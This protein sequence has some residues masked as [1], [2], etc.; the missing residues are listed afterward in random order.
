MLKALELIGFKSFPDKTRFEFP[1]GITVVVGP[2]G[3]GK[4][5]VVDAMKWVLGEQSARSLRGK[6][7]ADVIFKGSA[8]G[9]RKPA[10]TAQVTIIF[11]NSN[12]LLPVDEVEVHVTR[13]VYRSGEGEYLING[14]ACRLRDVRDLFRG[15]GVG[16]D[17]YSLIEQGKV[18]SLLQASAK[19]RRAI[20]E[21]AA[22]ISRFKAKKVEAERRLERVEQNLLRLSDIVE[23][24]ETRLKRLRSQATKATRYKEYTDRLQSLRTHVGRVDWQRLSEQLQGI[25]TRLT[26]LQ[27]E[28]ET[29][30]AELE[31]VEAR[32]AAE[33]T[34]ISSNEQALREVETSAGRYREQ[35]A[36]SRSTVAQQ[37]QTLHDLHEELSRGRDRLC[38]ARSKAREL[39]SQLEQVRGT[40][41][42]AESA[43]E[44]HRL[45][46]ERRRL[47]WHQR[48]AELTELR[49]QTEIRRAD[50]VERMRVAADVGN[51]IAGLELQRETVR[52]A[53]QKS[54]SLVE[55]ANR[56]LAVA[57][58][59][60]EAS[61]REAENSRSEVS[62]LERRITEL[63]SQAETRSA[64]IE[65]SIRQLGDLRERQT[66]QLARADVLREFEARMEGVGGGVK[67]VLAAAREGDARYAGVRGMI[68][69]IVRVT[70]AEMAGMVDVALGE[71]AQHL[72]VAGQQLFDLLER[73]QID[74]P[75]RV[76]FLRLQSTPPPPSAGWV[77]LE[78]Q[79]GVI[80]RADRFVETSS[81]YQHLVGWLLR[82]TWFVESL[83]DAI[84][85]H[86]TVSAPIRMVTRRGELLDR[87]GRLVVGPLEHGVG[88]I[89]RRAEL[90]EIERQARELEVEIARQHAEL[91]GQKEQLTRRQSERNDLI[92]EK[93]VLAQALSR[94]ELHVATATERAEQSRRERKRSAEELEQATRQ[95]AETERLWSENRD[96]LAQ[97]E[98]TIRGLE[99]QL[100]SDRESTSQ[101]EEQLQ[102]Q[103][104]EVTQWE[105]EVAKSE[106]RVEALKLQRT[107]LE[108]DQKDRE[109]QQRATTDELVRSQQRLQ[110]AELH[111][112]GAQTQIAEQSIAEQACRQ[113]I[114]LLA[115]QQIR[116]KQQRGSLHQ[117]ASQLRDRLHDAE[118]QRHAVQLD[119]QRIKHQRDTLFSRLEE[120]YGVSV[121]ELEEQPTEEETPQRD[122]IDREIDE[123]R[124]KISNLGAVNM[125]SLEDL[126]ELQQRYETLSTQYQD[127]VESKESLNKIITKINADSRRLFTET[128]EVVRAN[129]GV[130]FR[131]MF[132]GGKAD[133]VLEEGVDIL[134][135]GVDLV[136]TPPGKHSLSLSLLSG[137][138]RALTAVALL[139]A[140][141]QYRPSPFCVLDEV[142]G[143][144]DEANIG[145]FIDVLREFLQWTKFV[146]VTH[147]KRTMTAAHTLYG[148]TMQE[149][150]VSKRVAVRFE[151]V[152]EDG[153]ISD[154]AVR[155]S[156]PDDPSDDERGAA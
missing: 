33:E 61:V 127:L 137:G 82:D 151:D 124:R 19:D 93:Q 106:Q 50:F 28:I 32:I 89:S 66:A 145:R 1:P 63:E 29:S 70:S 26:S 147:S 81:E 121:A 144:L 146:V 136:A 2:N 119:G 17:A 68:A 6:E 112:L 12:R 94:L 52:E 54:S 132:G 37:S 153:V 91:E 18:D 96:Q 115:Q 42:A 71:R 15:T 102:V 143:P 103:Q 39:V 65:D 55:E 107:Q 60:C 109:D 111:I 21:E 45:E 138:E 156:Q 83:A 34:E 142:D 41:A 57:E 72:V 125:D 8:Q 131:K 155:R 53:I 148:I 11:D 7:M 97:L 20:F 130:L 30:Q 150:G 14:Q 86:R 13:R 120:D 75:G 95:L 47:L 9:K 116:L 87:D 88:L 98:S 140:I 152:G 16:T 51:K 114:E 67:Q 23:E 48:S 85:F 118:T 113:E 78:G 90:R 27:Q 40:H 25:E 69:D 74:F 5:N 92:A 149:S 76:G 79:S 104:L 22:G 35:I 64:V 117:Q 123:L 59:N 126:N 3:S 44:Q 73:E 110:D 43:F 135:A 108:Q 129:F 100:G 122:E 99:E 84:Q 77:N 49:R 24:V 4:S 105:V 133:I 38:A 101:L 80:G 128:L 46:F 31:E 141:F 58:E 36:A 10:N 139:L 62:A 56:R 154:A 134:E